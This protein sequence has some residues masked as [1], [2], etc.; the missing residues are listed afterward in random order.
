MGIFSSRESTTESFEKAL[1]ALDAQIRK[2]QVRFTDLKPRES[3]ARSSATLYALAFW[4]IVVAVAFNTALHTPVLLDVVHDADASPD[5]YVMVDGADRWK[6]DALRMFAV[7]IGP[8][9]LFWIRRLVGW[10]FRR[11]RESSIERLDALKAK[12][13]AKIEELK[14]ITAFYRAKELIERYEHLLDPNAP[15]QPSPNTPFPH[16]P[17][18]PGN[19]SRGGPNFDPNAPP[20][21]QVPPHLMIPPHQQQQGGPDGPLDRSPSRQGQRSRASSMNERVSP[22][23]IEAPPSTALPQEE[24]QNQQ[25]QQ[26]Q[27]SGWF[28]RLVE[29]VVVGGSG[30]E[31]EGAEA[32]AKFALICGMCHHHNGLA[33]PAE[34]PTLRFICRVCATL[35]DRGALATGGPWL[36][37]KIAE[38]APLPPHPLP[39]PPVPVP[40][41]TPT[42]PESEQILPPAVPAVVPRAIV[43][44]PSESGEGGDVHPMNIPLPPSPY[45]Q[46]PASPAAPFRAAADEPVP[47]IPATVLVPPPRPEAGSPTSEDD[48]ERVDKDAASSLASTPSTTRTATARSRSRGPAAPEASS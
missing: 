48:W 19:V 18:G 43:V 8:F 25:N 41:M 46:S 35:N 4:G 30:S 9:I 23:A 29:R 2:E 1:D 39:Q 42:P 15:Q 6:T 12:Q 11:A 13:R 16:G 28:G 10:Y 3:Y 27:G 44:P 21:Q 34:F 38:P 7:A 33:W 37:Q 31:E 17:F 20:G 47:P 45:P 36:F 24:Q 40:T 26:Q 14:K 22:L 5:S 32:N